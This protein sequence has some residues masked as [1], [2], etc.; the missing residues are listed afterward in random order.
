MGHGN[1]DTV[2]GE[3]FPAGLRARRGSFSAARKQVDAIAA[4]SIIADADE[5]PP[6]PAW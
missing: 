1:E 3:G 2:L 6:T 5:V 4:P